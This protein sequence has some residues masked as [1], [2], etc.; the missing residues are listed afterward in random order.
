MSHNDAKQLVKVIRGQIG[1]RPIDTSQLV[2]TVSGT[3]VYLNGV[4]RPL[5]AAGD[6]DM[7]VEMN[8]ISTILRTKPGIKDVVWDVTLRS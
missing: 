2:I 1:R 8:A 7:Q 4:V 6:V 5:R 3:T